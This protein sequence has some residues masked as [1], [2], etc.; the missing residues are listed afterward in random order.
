MVTHTHLYS[1]NYMTLSGLHSNDLFI[2]FL[3]VCGGG[4]GHTNRPFNIMLMIKILMQRN[5]ELK[6]VKS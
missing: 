4:G 5:L 3:F 6:S 2:L 1:L